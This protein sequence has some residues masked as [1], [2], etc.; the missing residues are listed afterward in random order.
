MAD[1]FEGQKQIE[2]FPYFLRSAKQSP[3]KPYTTNMVSFVIP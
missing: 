3:Y 2:R 1:G